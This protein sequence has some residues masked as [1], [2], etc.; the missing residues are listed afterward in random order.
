MKA[1]A[2]LH[3]ILSV[4]IL[5]LIA[6]PAFAIGNPAL[7]PADLRVFFDA[8]VPRQLEE[9]SIPGATIS[10]VV[11]GEMAFAKGYGVA[12]VETGQPVIADRT[13]FHVGSI[14][15]LFVWTAVMQ[16]AEQGKLDLH[17]DVNTYLD[18]E[19][20]DTY[21]E[22]ITLAHLLTH[23]PGFEDKKS[24]LF[25]FSTDD[26]VDLDEYVVTQ[27]PKRVY[28][29]GE[30]VAYSNYG[31]A[32]AGYIV[33]QVSEQSYEQ[34]IQEHILGPLGMER[35]TLLQP[36]PPEL[37]ADT[38][39]GHMQMPGGAPK[40]IQEYIP[41]GPAGA[42]SATA[43]D[44][45]QFMI[46]HLQEGRY[47]DTHI[48]QAATAQE[49]HRQHY[50]S[51]PR[52]PGITYGF[53]EW[54]RNDQHIIWHSGGTAL[55]KSLL[56]LLPEHDVGL[57]IS[58]NSPSGEDARAELRQA[59][60]DRCY[61]A[62][63]PDPKPLAEAGH[64]ASRFAGAYREARWAYHTVDRLF[65]ALSASQK[66][67]AN[68]D[69][70]LHF[71]DRDFVEVEPLVF[72]E[73]GG[74]TTLIFHE[75]ARGRITHAFQDYE[76]HEAYIKL[77]WYETAGFHLAMLGV[78]GTILAASLVGWAIGGLSSRRRG[79]NATDQRVPGLARKLGA[80]VAGLHVMF[81]IVTVL[82]GL[83]I[84]VGSFPNL[85]LFGPVFATALILPLAAGILTIGLVVFAV[86]VWRNGYWGVWGRVHYTLVTLAALGLVW[87]LNYWNLLGFRY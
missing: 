48:L 32:L 69:G 46:A 86:L 64:Q 17:A 5:G 25:A 83:T 29:P 44:M 60:L 45:A 16:L 73:V 18:F 65:F 49:M 79:N 72:R 75:D 85:S 7:D 24:N 11:D 27:L 76:P 58:Y 1:R 82:G 35:T 87:W 63:T 77:A 21:P 33:A 62:S 80:T 57:F 42:M 8:L 52:L 36:V 47:G 61:P 6:Q 43:T 13:L 51:D 41:A 39:M 67:R 26:L 37:A 53:M 12:N 81:P 56:M 22:P 84:L 68:P 59:F 19:I 78:L 40:A 38:A 3:G 28:A 34:Y 31:A 2:L 71:R 30:I 70:T 74:Q 23:T 55:F 15:K 4:L 14:T 66:V 9:Y 10:V 54:E 20:P 50:A